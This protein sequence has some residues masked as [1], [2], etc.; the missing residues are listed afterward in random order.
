LGR[1]HLSARGQKNEVGRRNVFTSGAV[2][3]LIPQ[4]GCAH[5]NENKPL[6]PAP[7]SP[8]LF[9][10]RMLRVFGVV[11]GIAPLLTPLYISGL[12]PPGFDEIETTFIGSI[13][14]EEKRVHTLLQ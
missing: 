13:E 3:S 8:L 7:A 2:F 6:A 1:L 5:Q 4:R 14:R 10:V 11:I 9:G 12:N